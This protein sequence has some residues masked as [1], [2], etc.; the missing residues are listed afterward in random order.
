MLDWDDFRSESVTIELRY[1]PAFA[2]WDVAGRIWGEILGKFPDLRLASVMPN[3]QVFES[4]RLRG[5]VELEVCRFMSVPPKPEFQATEATQVMFE[6]CARLL[7]FHEITRL[8]FRMVRTLPFPSAADSINFVQKTMSVPLLKPLDGGR[9]VTAFNLT[10]KQE[11]DT[12]GLTAIIRVEQREI[13]ISFPWEIQGRLPSNVPTTLE[14]EF[15]VVLDS[16]YFTTAPVEPEVVN[17]SEW[18]RQATRSI[19]KYWKEKGL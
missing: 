5:S 16:D 6:A 2:L 4:P 11:D 7:R 9:R 17:I 18:S 19:K 12:S 3:Q 14:K 1:P 8:G 15:L 13:K 10:E